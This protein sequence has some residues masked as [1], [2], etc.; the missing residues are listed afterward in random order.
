MKAKARLSVFTV[1]LVGW[2]LVCGLS[3]VAQNLN[4]TGNVNITA[5]QYAYQIEGSNVLRIRVGP[6]GGFTNLFVGKSAGANVNAAGGVFVGSFSGFNT[7]TGKENSFVGYQSGY[8]NVT[9]TSNTFVGFRTAGSSGVFGSATG[10]GSSNTFVGYQAG[11]NN[12]DGNAN[13]FLGSFSGMF[14]TTGTRNVFV[15]LSSGTHNNKGNANIYISNPGPMPEESNTIRIGE[16]F[17]GSCNAPL[18]GINAAYIAGIY[19]SSVNSGKLVCVDST[20]KL[21]TS[22]TIGLGA[23]EDMIRSQAQRI[24]DLELRLSRLEALLA[25][26]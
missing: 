21:G 24:E 4:V 17:S 16:A 20:G 19:G 3:A 12:T 1:F 25:Q 11:F 15:G 5:T 18:C 14:N 26:K 22:C 7:T 6:G 23:Q 9:G 8:N 13:T 2:L 10:R